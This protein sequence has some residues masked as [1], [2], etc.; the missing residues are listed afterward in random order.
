MTDFKKVRIMFP[1]LQK[2]II[3]S[4]EDTQEPYNYV[5]VIKGHALVVTAYSVIFLDLQEYFINYIALEGE[6]KE[7]FLELLN[8]ME[9]KHFTSDFW[10]YLT[11]WNVVHVIDENRINISGDRF[12]KELVY[13]HDDTINLRN[14]MNMIVNNSKASKTQLPAIAI[15]NDVLK[16][17]D[18]TIGKLINKNALIFEFISLN[19]TIRFS[20]DSMPCVFGILLSSNSVTS[21]PYLFD[22]FKDFALKAELSLF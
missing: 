13:T 21:K 7:A 22:G 18:K 5:S 14:A 4:K 3:K 9:D 15:S 8:W 2:G 12:E 16:I 1:A 11:H 6:D 17:V 19:S 10:T 20:V